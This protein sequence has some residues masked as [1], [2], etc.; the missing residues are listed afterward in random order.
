[1]VVKAWQDELTRQAQRSGQRPF[2]TIDGDLNDEFLDLV[3]EINTVVGGTRTIQA[4]IKK[5][6]EDVADARASA[7]NTEPAEHGQLPYVYKNTAG[8]DVAT[9]DGRY[10]WQ[11]THGDH[12]VDITMGPWKI[13]SIQEKKYGI[14]WLYGRTCLE[15]RDYCDN[16]SSVRVNGNSRTESCRYEKFSVKGMTWDLGARGRT[17]VKIT[18]TD[19]TNRNVGL[20]N[21]NPYPGRIEKRSCP[22]FHPEN[23]ALYRI[24]RNAFSGWTF[25]LNGWGVTDARCR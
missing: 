5:F 10:A 12:A 19:P 21:W 7:L 6:Y 16:T 14:G 4:A 17:W 24:D 1:L 20:W 13:P 11:D 25:L 8:R 3:N 22:Q 9:V 2:G 18:R 15:L 23:V